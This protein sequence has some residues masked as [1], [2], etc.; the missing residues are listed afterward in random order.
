METVNLKATVRTETGRQAKQL[1]ETGKI[2]A[3]LYGHGVE[4]TNIAFDRGEFEKIFKTA[5]SSTIVTL[6]IEGKDAVKALILDPQYDPLTD[7]IIH[8]DLYKVNMKEE[9]HTEIPLTFVGESAAVKDFQ[10]NLITNKDEI[11][12]KCLPDK[13]VSEI[14]V[15][16]SVLA[17]FDDVIKVSD[18]NIP[19]G[20]EVLTEAEEVVAMVTAPRSEEEMEAMEAETAGDAEKAAIENI[21]A[22]TEAEKAEKAEGEEKAE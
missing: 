19:E 4:N 16:I 22:A 12:V 21:E 3:V 17:T 5:G 11:E 10:G 1:R 15:D 8:V 14:E 6:K 7:K 18:L 9:I 20:I 13:L 2:P